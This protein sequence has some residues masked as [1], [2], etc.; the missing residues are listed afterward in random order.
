MRQDF[1]PPSAPPY[2]RGS[3]FVRASYVTGLLL[4]VAGLPLIA[5]CGGSATSTPPGQA[6]YKIKHIIIIMQENRSFDN[7]F[8]TFPGAD[9][10]PMIDGV[11]TVCVNDPATGECVKPY[12]D[13]SDLNGGGPHGAANA[14]ADVDGGKMDGF[15]AQAESGRKG[16]LASN[17]PLCT[18]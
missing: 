12:H 8:G 3:R 10:I 18:G 9:G 6:A 4:L 16:C 13:P 7:Y 11:P 17:S 1:S 2:R 15:V 14:A 5:A